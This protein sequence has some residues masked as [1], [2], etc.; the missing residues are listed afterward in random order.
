MDQPQ[1][2]ECYG[3]RT[4]RSLARRVAGC[5]T[6]L[7]ALACFSALGQELAPRAYWPGPAGLNVL[8]LGYAFTDGDVLVDPSLPVE[9]VNAKTHAL[10]LI[11]HR[12]F[13]PLF[14]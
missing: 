12:F 14:Y 9:G 8:S 10:S 11:Y 13:E 6:V 7:L 1:S 4:G 5:L 2:V 3:I